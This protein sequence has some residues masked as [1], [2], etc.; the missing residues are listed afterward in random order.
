MAAQKSHT[1]DL[2]DNCEWITKR[3]NDGSTYRTKLSDCGSTKCKYS[4]S[5]VPPQ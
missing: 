4:D 1:R 2:V 3:R 5:Y